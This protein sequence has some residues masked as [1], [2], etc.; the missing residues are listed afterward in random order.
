MRPQELIEYVSIFNNKLINC[1]GRY[2]NYFPE[3]NALISIDPQEGFFHIR[4]WEDK[5]SLLND[6]LYLST[7]GCWIYS[8][9]FEKYKNE[10]EFDDLDQAIK[11][12]AKYLNAIS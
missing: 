8:K 7:D 6:G 5:S 1:N 11:A 10:L 2:I 4:K 3:L 12:I 9:Y